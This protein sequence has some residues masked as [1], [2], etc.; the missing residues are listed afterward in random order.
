M[1]LALLPVFP[2]TPGSHMLFQEF[3]LNQAAEPGRALLTGAAVSRLQHPETPSLSA[4]PGTRRH[5]SSCG[6]WFLHLSPRQEESLL[7]GIFRTL[8]HR[9][10]SYL[11]LFTGA[12]LWRDNEPAGTSVGAAAATAE[13]LPA[14]PAKPKASGRWQS[15]IQPLKTSPLGPNKVFFQ[16]FNCCVWSFPPALNSACPGRWWE[17][18]NVAFDP[19]R[20]TRWDGLC[21]ESAIESQNGLGWKGP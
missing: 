7:Q 15:K 17:D 14:A 10:C 5:W 21:R 18:A 3:G 11:D 20:A 2:D 19:R 8:L 6:I 16:R 13:E 12:K 4:W 1:P 9:L